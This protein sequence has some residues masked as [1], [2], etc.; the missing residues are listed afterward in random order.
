MSGSGQAELLLGV[1]DL[2]HLLQLL[3]GESQDV[4]GAELADVRPREG[5]RPR[6]GRGGRRRA[7]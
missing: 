5:Q 4:E 3:A 2:V 6:L 1:Q 7:A